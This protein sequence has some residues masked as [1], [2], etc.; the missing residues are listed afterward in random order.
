MPIKQYRRRFHTPQEINAIA[1]E[2]GTIAYTMAKEIDPIEKLR[3]NLNKMSALQAACFK[4]FKA[5]DALIHEL[6]IANQ[7]KESAVNELQAA[8]P[9]CFPSRSAD[10]KSLYT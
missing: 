7:R 3:L 9:Q 2:N 8:S 5:G 6:K 1:H 10:R 4:R